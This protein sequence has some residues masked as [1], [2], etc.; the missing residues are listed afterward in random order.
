MPILQ[1][2]N[3]IRSAV[4]LVHGEKAHSCYF[5]R[6]AYAN[7]I[8]DSKYTDNK[9]L[10]IIPEAVHTDLY[11]KTDVIP[12]ERM[13]RLFKEYLIWW[14]DILLSQTILESQKNNLRAVIFI[15][16]YV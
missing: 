7:M 2:S 5:S 9:E 6:D 14:M 15:I 3:E 13:E 1:Y 10:L 11:D 12:F 4:L 8:K 16:V